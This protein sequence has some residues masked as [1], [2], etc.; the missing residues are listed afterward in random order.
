MITQPTEH[1]SDRRILRSA[2]ASTDATQTTIYLGVCDVHNVPVRENKLGLYPHLAPKHSRVLCFIGG[3]AEEHEIV[4]EK[5]IAVETTLNCDSTCRA[6][7]GRSCSCGCGGTN[8]GDHWTRQY[9]LEHL[10]MFEAEVAKYRYEV[11]KRKLT[12]EN[13]AREIFEAWMTAN[14][15]EVAWFMNEENIRSGFLRSMKEQLQSMK[16][17]SEGQLRVVR[18]IR[19][20]EAEGRARWQVAERQQQER[21]AREQARNANKRPGQGDQSQL[22]VGVYR[23]GED[24]YVLK[25]NRAYLSWRKNNRLNPDDQRPRPEEALL[26]AN[27]W[28]RTPG[29]RIAETDREIFGRLEYAKGVIF[30]IAPEDRMSLE[31]ARDWTQRFSQ[32]IVCGARLE[33]R[34]SIE[35]GMGSTCAGYFR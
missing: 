21:E 15:D 20:E 14:A 10:E 29:E 35:R 28:V 26:Y 30:R 22:T 3:Q 11:E 1:L 12:K 18:T 2:H 13:K 31:D 7:R 33:L 24:I 34:E 25:G 9:M 17:L 16:R 8:H 23:L 4:G 27:K 19:Q 32:C 6:A 5:L